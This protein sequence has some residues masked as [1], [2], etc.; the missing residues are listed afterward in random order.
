MRYRQLGWTGLAVSE[1]GIGTW[2]IGGV[3]IMSGRP[4]SYGEADDA[5]AIRMIHWAIDH[6]ITFIDT[7]PVYGFGHSEEIVGQALRGRRDKVVLETKVG[8]HHVNYQQAFD[9]SPAFVRRSID[10]S[11][12]RLQTDHI[13]CFVL[14][15]PHDGGVSTEQALEAIDA[16]RETGKVRAVGA[17][18]YDNAMGIELIRSGRCQII[19][20]GL[21]LIQ[22]D[23]SP[24]LLAAAGEHG[25]GVVV[26]QALHRGFL[27]GKITRETVFSPND[28]RSRRSRDEVSRILDRV[29]QFEFLLDGGRRT[30]VDAA[31]LYALSRPAVSTVLSGAISQ[32]ELAEA[33]ATQ[34]A[35][36][37]TDAELRRIAE[38]QAQQAIAAT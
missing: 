4:N 37:L 25:V 5:E 29:E 7:A 15:L 27:T 9:F 33:V 22:P 36:A 30:M 34:D 10:E 35:P 17:S 20:H 14:H 16:A 11:L 32:Q 21:S 2:G 24:E 8:E 19:Q 1:I 26:R 3:Q 31:L 28:M 12:Q 18:I 23:A 6:G 13:D 38:V